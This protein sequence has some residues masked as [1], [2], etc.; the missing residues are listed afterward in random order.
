MI[1]IPLKWTLNKKPKWNNKFNE[2]E[3][4]FYYAKKQEVDTGR[5]RKNCKVIIKRMFIH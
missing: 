5:K 2:T 1:I 4:V 3:E